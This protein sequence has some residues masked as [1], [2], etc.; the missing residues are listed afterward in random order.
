MDKTIYLAGAMDHVSPEFATTW[1]RDATARLKAAGFTVLDPTAGKPLDH[2]DA[3]TTLYTPAQIVEADKA[4]IDRAGIVLA[5][6]SKR[7]IPYHGTSMEILYAWERK[8]R[9][10]AWG[11]S[12]S[13]WVRYHSERI[14]LTLHEALT[15]L[16]G[17]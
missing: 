17:R 8:K 15:Y 5:E 3:N 6:V 13:Y 2:P 9:V 1:R 4:M 11:G 14:F 12:R 16:E 7:N 10:I